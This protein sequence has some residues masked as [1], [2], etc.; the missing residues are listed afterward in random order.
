MSQKYEA[1]GFS[2]IGSNRK[3]DSPSQEITVNI[4]G[5]QKYHWAPPDHY[6]G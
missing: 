3:S 4:L 2:K 5:K 6:I 1:W